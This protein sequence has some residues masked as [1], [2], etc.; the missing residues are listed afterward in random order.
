M[1]SIISVGVTF[2]VTPNGEEKQLSK[3]VV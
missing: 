2:R 3:A 1:A